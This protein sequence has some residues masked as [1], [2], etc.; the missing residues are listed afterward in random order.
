MVWGTSTG[1]TAG[2]CLIWACLVIGTAGMTGLTIFASTLLEMA[3]IHAPQLALFMVCAG[4]I[5]YLGYRDIRLSSGLM[6][7]IEGLSCALILL[8]C[9]IVLFGQK[10]MFDTNQITLQGASFSGISLGVVVAIFS[11]VGFECATAFGEEARNPFQ[12]IP[13]AVL[14]SLLL[15]GV[16][17]VIVTYS[18]VL[19]FAG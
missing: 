13:R 14:F 11:L 6:L 10:S 9:G 4:S 2:W 5:W 12:T 7:V 1:N 19:G 16:F 8:L 17:F 3:G 18:E 15:T